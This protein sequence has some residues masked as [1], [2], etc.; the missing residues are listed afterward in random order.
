MK[1]CLEAGGMEFVTTYDAFTKDAPR[2]DSDRIYVI[3][4]EKG[5]QHV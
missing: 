4:R 5:K 2:P 3:A 1:A